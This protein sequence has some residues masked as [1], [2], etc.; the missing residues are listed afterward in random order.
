M[1]QPQTPFNL[2][3]RPIMIWSSIDGWEQRTGYRSADE[4]MQAAVR[5]LSRPGNYHKKIEFA[6][7][8]FAKRGSNGRMDIDLGYSEFERRADYL[9]T[10]NVS[11]NVQSAQITR[12]RTRTE[13]NGFTREHGVLQKFDLESW[14]SRFRAMTNRVI[15]DPF[16]EDNDSCLYA[17]HHAN[18]AGERVFHGGFILTKTGDIHCEFSR[19]AFGEPKFSQKS[20]KVMQLARLLLTNRGI[21]DRYPA[22]E[23]H[24]HTDIFHDLALEQAVKEARCLMVA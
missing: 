14:N 2:E 20:E 5:M 18:R 10:G 8:W 24:D 4:R 12:P 3:L 19:C 17:F 7:A 21:E 11:S 9:G 15:T 23:R 16:F 1:S 22:F 13:C 6:N